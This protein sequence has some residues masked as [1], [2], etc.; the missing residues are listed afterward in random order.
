MYRELFNNFNL[1]KSEI[2]Q[3]GKSKR[4][5]MANHVEICVCTLVPFKNMCGMFTESS[6][7]ELFSCVSIVRNRERKRWKRYIHKIKGIVCTTMYVLC[8]YLCDD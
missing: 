2:N 6:V 3:L 5:P 7:T 4:Q 8:T 1:I